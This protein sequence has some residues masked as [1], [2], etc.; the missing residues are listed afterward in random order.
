[1]EKIYYS[2]ASFKKDAQD[3]TNSCRDFNPE[4]ILAVARGGLT[5]S[6][7]MAQALNIRNLFAINSI[8]YENNSRSLNHEIFNI[9]NLSLYKRVLIVDDIVDSGHTMKKLLEILELEYKDIDFKVATIFY[10]ETALVKPDFYI[11]KADKW[12]EFFWEV[13]IK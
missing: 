12:I 7:L 6:H 1:M 2:Y 10:K 9:P 13:D 5:L 3:L 11:K 4:V 8:S